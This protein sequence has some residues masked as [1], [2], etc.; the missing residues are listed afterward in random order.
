M[1]KGVGHRVGEQS[2]QVWSQIKP[3]ALIAR[4]MTQAHW[5]QGY[6][7]VFDLLSRLKQCALP[8]LLDKKMRNTHTAIGAS[9]RCIMMH[10][11]CLLAALCANMRVVS[12]CCR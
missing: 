5:W 6:S 11:S 2:E 9:V 4:Y 1:Q 3:F 12:S 10:G 7:L 8:E